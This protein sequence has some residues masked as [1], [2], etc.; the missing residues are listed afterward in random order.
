MSGSMLA[1]KVLARRIKPFVSSLC[2]LPIF[3]LDKSITLLPFLSR[4]AM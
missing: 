1:E 2:A 4:R 3:K